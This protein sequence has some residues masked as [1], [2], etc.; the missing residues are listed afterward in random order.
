MTTTATKKAAK[1]P[2]D[3][4]EDV[5][6]FTDITDAKQRADDGDADAIVEVA[7]EMAVRANAT[8]NG[9]G[10]WP[11]DLLLKNYVGAERARRTPPE[12]TSHE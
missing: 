3:D 4:A 5:S 12:Y 8:F 7:Q 11:E 10:R 9:G 1:D 2:A 6:A